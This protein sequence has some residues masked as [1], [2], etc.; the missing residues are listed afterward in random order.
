MPDS[1]ATNT[2]V[3]SNIWSS[4]FLIT[5]ILILFWFLIIRPQSKK[6]KEHQILIN[7]LQRG[8]KVL[9]HSGI[10]G[11]ITKINDTTCTLEIADNVNI[12]IDK[13]Y[14]AGQYESVKSSNISTKK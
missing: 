7:Q 8:D 13:N 3:T 10:I 12:I 5:S 1:V 11:K 2:H 6:I 4:V 9:T 14:I